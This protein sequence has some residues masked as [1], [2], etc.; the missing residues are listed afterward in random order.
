M[1]PNTSAAVMN[2][3]REPPDSLDYF[4]TPP[5]AARAFCDHVF[6]GEA[7]KLIAY[8]PACGEGH[9]VAGLRDAFGTVHGSDV[10]DYGRN[11][12]VSD[13][14][15]TT[16]GT[17]SLPGGRVDWI[18]TNPPFNAALDFLKAAFAARPRKGIAFLLRTVWLESG[19]RHKE[20][21]DG[22]LRPVS[23]YISVDRIPMVKGRYDHGARSAT[24]YAWFVFDVAQIERCQTLRMN[25]LPP[26]EVKWLPPGGRKKF[27]DRRDL[28]IGAWEPEGELI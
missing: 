19:E 25:Q 14:L 11:F 26:V 17:K 21:F 28:T 27:Y 16:L 13:F 23:V 6:E 18:I 24:S 7:K 1:T 20:I 8:D 5:W 22:P 9:M 12:P 3:R 4:P 2:Q 15:D 10:F